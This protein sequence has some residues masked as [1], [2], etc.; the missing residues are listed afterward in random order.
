MSW[1]CVEDAIETENQ[2]IEEIRAMQ[3]MTRQQKAAQRKH[4]D[5][6]VS[7]AA[8]GEGSSLSSS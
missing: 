3:R 1:T 5:R 6:E 8:D 2:W 7:V 4:L